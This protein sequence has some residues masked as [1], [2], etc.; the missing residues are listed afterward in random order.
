MYVHRTNMTEAEYLKWIADYAEV[1]RR[2]LA[3][4][5]P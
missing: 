3:V 2:V 4:L 5:P 1:F